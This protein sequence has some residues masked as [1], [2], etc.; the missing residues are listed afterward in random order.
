MLSCWTEYHAGTGNGTED[1]ISLTI[2]CAVQTR[3][4]SPWRT[5]PDTWR[6]CQE[7]GS[8]LFSVSFLLK[9]IVN[10]LHQ[11]CGLSAPYPAFISFSHALRFKNKMIWTKAGITS[12]QHYT[13][14]LGASVYGQALHPTGAHWP[15][16]TYSHSCYR[17]R[18][19][20]LQWICSHPRLFLLLSSMI[21]CV[22]PR[23]DSAG[24]DAALPTG[25]SRFRFALG[26]REFFNDIILPA[27]LWSWC[28]NRF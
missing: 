21:A 10:I 18:A 11:V 7:L 24:W 13:T 1:F 26:S 5:T 28:R 17:T 27:T 22:R 9:M 20:C 8:E 25:I 6:H 2:L 14:K 12:P 23:G 15:T 4:Y 16:S 19:Q 3:L